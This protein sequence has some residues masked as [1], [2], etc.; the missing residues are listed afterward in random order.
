MAATL[1]SYQDVQ[2]LL[3]KFLSDN[4]LSAA[5]APHGVF[6]HALTYEQFITEQV[7]VLS[8]VRIVVPKSAA[9]SGIIQALTGTGPFN[10]NSGEYPQMPF[11]SPPYSGQQDVIDAL[12]AWIDAGC[13]NNSGAGEEVAVTSKVNSRNPLQ[14]KLAALSC[15]TSLSFARDIRPL[16]SD[17]DVEH[18]KMRLDLSNYQDVK[19][20]AHKIYQLVSEHIMPPPGSPDHPWSDDKVDTFGCW[21]QQGCQP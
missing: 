18:M 10:P 15:T 6:W 3:D 4:G 1:N 16:F 12:T 19:I 11:P 21:M 7:P 14:A 9:T 2:N 13:P 20:W 17:E 5:S 8:D